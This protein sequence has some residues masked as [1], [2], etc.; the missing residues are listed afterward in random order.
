MGQALAEGLGYPYQ[1]ENVQILSAF[2]QVSAGDNKPGVSIAFK[3]YSPTHAAAAGVVDTLSMYIAAYNN[4]AGFLQVLHAQA[5]A[6][7]TTN[8]TREIDLVT[9]T[10]VPSAGDLPSS[11]IQLGIW[12]FASSIML[13]AGCLCCRHERHHPVI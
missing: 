8:F 1:S 2:D 13:V 9:V 4:S 12:I 7:Q 3:V 10:A 5:K 11:P 6:D